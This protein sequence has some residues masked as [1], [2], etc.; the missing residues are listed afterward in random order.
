MLP[1]KMFRIDTGFLYPVGRKY[2]GSL[3][4]CWLLLN[5]QPV[6][7]RLLVPDFVATVTA[8]PPAIPCSASKLPVLTLTVSMDSDGCTIATW[9]GSQMLMLT[10]PSVRVLLL[11]VAVPFTNERKARPGVSTTAFWNS[12]GLDR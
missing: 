4:K 1:P 7:C 10:A 2:V 3:L 9:W 12:G 6:P 5:H 8:A 11:F